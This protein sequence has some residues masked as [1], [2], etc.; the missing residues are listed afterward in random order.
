PGTYT[1]WVELEDNFGQLHQSNKV[2]F[3]LEDIEPSVPLEL[4]E[5]EIRLDKN[6]YT[7]AELLD[8]G[9]EYSFKNLTDETVTFI[10]RLSFNTPVQSPVF[11]LVIHDTKGRMIPIILSDAPGY[12]PI[13]K[14]HYIPVHPGEQ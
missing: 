10:R 5:L 13:E 7:I 2:D 14:L 11:E 12:V 3:T 4:L 9:L 8:V 1:F 6:S